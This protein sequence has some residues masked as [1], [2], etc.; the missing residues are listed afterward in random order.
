MLERKVSHRA[1]S[2]I[3]SFDIA[4][5]SI[6]VEISFSKRNTGVGATMQE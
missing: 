3:S 4:K 6:D 2:R 1:Y 5:L